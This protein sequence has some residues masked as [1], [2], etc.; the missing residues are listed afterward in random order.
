MLAAALVLAACGS[1]NPVAAVSSPTPSGTASTPLPSA[2]PSTSSSPSPSPAGGASPSASPSSA[3]ATAG[4]TLVIQD[5]SH[6]QVR[7]ARL[8]ATDV[9]AVTGMF[10]GVV[11][12]QAI[13]LSGQT[14]LA[15]A[16]TGSM[17]TLGHLAGAPEWS[18][19]GTVVVNPT[20]TQW[21][22]TVADTSNWTSQIH[23]GTPSGDPV[24]ATAPSPDGY[25]FYEAFA[26]NPSG[27]Y[28]V[29][30][31]T[32]LGG[33]GPFLEYHFPLEKIDVV[34]GVITAVTPQ[35]VAERVLDDGTMLCQNN[36]GG[37]EVRSPAGASHVIQL[38]KSTSAGYA[39]FSRLA[40]TP[41][42]R[43]FAAARNG[44]SNQ[45][46]VN[47]QIASGDLSSSTAGVFGPIDFYPDTWLPDGR[48]VAD[49]L[50]WTFQGNGG[51]CDQSLDGTYFLSAD[52]QSRTL[53]YKLAQGA[54]VVGY[55]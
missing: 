1:P 26:W 35:C 10:D 21:L 5:Y 25:D 38:A 27:A 48:L 20:L 42:Q 47:Y 24:I 11:A 28:L 13:V 2:P 34:T 39:I 51:P 37:L 16:A 50:C 41:D 30:Q 4:T 7:I 32:G 36:T 53:F 15:V 19:P 29:K 49:H 46:L 8:D 3:P 18:G 40:L 22:Y 6:N 43:H 31:G 17:R 52:G 54:S 55:L 9:G 23:L 45:D 33:V 14:L 44:S 12:D